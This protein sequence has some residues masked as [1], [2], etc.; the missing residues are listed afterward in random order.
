ML[1]H[2]DVHGPHLFVG[3]DMAIPRPRRAVDRPRAVVMAG[4]TASGKTTLAAR[5]SHAGFERLTASDL[6]LPMVGDPG[7]AKANRLLSWL[8]AAPPKPRDGQADRRTDLTVLR[9]LAAA[10]HVV[11][12]SAGS[13]PLLLSPCNHALL[14]RLVAAPQVR[15][16]RL[17]RLLEGRAD[18][19]EA[20]Q[21][22]Q[23]KDEATVS[24]CRRA[25][26]LDLTDQV[27]QRRY[28]LIIGCPDSSSCTDPERC[29]Q[30]I[31]DLAH[32]AVSVYRGYLAADQRTA[33][34]GITHLRGAVARWRPWVRHISG[35]L[36]RPE[37]EVTPQRWFDR[38]VHDT[39]H[40]DV[41]RKEASC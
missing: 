22:V 38:L 27:H 19:R 28:D 32:A 33:A 17:Y 34:N 9:M 35:A 1:R 3:A 23:R 29:Q 26:G 39:G 30:A 20:A 5:M 36:I 40:L 4:W 6:L 13:I 16:E 21:I 7:S 15:A 10:G 11:V 31:D 2:H 24:A 14:I 25:W 12:E 41:P 18:L 8:S 37:A